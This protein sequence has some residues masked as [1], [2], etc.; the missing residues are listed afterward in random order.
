[1]PSHLRPSMLAIVW[2]AILI[3]CVRSPIG[4]FF[5]PPKS[6]PRHVFEMINGRCELTASYPPQ[7][8]REIVRAPDESITV[9]EEDG[10]FVTQGAPGSLTYALTLE[11]AAI[12]AGALFVLWQEEDKRRERQERVRA[13]GGAGI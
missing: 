5:V 12:N 7:T 2:N 13:E 8:E 3:R 6:P 9:I 1:M 4:R 11:E 10:Q